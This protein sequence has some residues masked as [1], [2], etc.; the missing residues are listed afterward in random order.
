MKG[1]LPAGAVLVVGTLLGL[2]LHQPVFILLGLVVAVGMVALMGMRQSMSHDSV[3]SLDDLPPEER[4]LLLP[5]KKAFQ[6]LKQVV[7]ENAGSATVQMLGKEAEA[8]AGRIFEQAAKSLRLRAELR[9]VLKGRY[10]AE[11]D[12]QRLETQASSATEVEREA[13][14]SASEARK[15]ELGHYTII[16]ENV[17]KIDAGLRLA[18]AA[19]AEIKARLNVGASGEKLAENGGEEL[20]ESLARLKSISL[21]YDEAQQLLKE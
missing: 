3:V 20:R 5:V 12:I 13:L 2:L 7:Q 17:A 1:F 15:T 16:E 9:K 21:S 18:Q 11:R 8:E 6:D 10:D 14:S 19:L 4:T